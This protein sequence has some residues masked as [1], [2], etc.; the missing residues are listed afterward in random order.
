[1]V[2]RLQVQGVLR[3]IKIRPL[4]GKLPEPA[5]RHHQIQAG[6][7]REDIH[8]AFVHKGSHLQAQALLVL[9]FGNLLFRPACFLCRGHS[10]RQAL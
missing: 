8:G 10:R 5:L 6:I 9:L 4:S 1:M 2:L 7:A 3:Q